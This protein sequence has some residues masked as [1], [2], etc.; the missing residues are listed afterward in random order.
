VKWLLL[1]G[2]VGAPGFAILAQAVPDSGIPPLVGT[3]ISLPFLCWLW[4]TE[5]KARMAAEERERAV[6]T[7]SAEKV[8]GAVDVLGRALEV[9]KKA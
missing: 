8:Y 6:L 5:R 1:A 3:V 7:E 2:L 4:W 9:V